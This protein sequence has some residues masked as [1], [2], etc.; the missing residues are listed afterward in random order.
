[1][2]LSLNHLAG[3]SPGRRTIHE[4]QFLCSPD[5]ARAQ[6]W[7]HDLGLS[8]QRR[9]QGSATPQTL[10]IARTC[11]EWSRGR[12]SPNQSLLQAN[13]RGALAPHPLLF[14]RQA[15]VSPDNRVASSFARRILLGVRSPLCKGRILPHFRRRP[16]FLA[17]VRRT[18]EIVI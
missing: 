9:R 11:F 3:R 10:A 14:Q 2:L 16:T 15:M 6:N 13:S 12:G 7:T 4:P 17:L 18:R 5:G 1:M 8:P